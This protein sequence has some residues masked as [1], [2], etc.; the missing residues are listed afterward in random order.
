MCKTRGCVDMVTVA[1]PTDKM[2]L[3]IDF[4]IGPID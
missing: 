1:E 3:N 2:Q 4:G